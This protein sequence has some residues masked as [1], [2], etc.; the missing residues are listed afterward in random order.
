MIKEIQSSLESIF[1][2]PFRVAK[3]SLHGYPS[4]TIYPD[5]DGE[6]LFEVSIFFKDNIRIV[7]E[8]VP[9]RFAARS[10]QD[11]SK[12]D[13]EKRTAA[14]LYAKAIIK[15]SAKIDFSVNASSVDPLDFKT[16]PVEW[17]NFSCRITKI[18]VDV[19]GQV[20]D[21]PSIVVEWATKAIGMFLSLLNVEQISLENQEEGAKHISV[22]NRYERSSINR[23]LCLLKHGYVCKICGMSFERKYGELGKNYIHVHHIV[24]VS[25]MGGSYIINP[26]TDLI[27][28]CPNC[29]AMLHRQ[30]PPLTPEQLIEI[31]QNNAK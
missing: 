15:Q 7:L 28:V 27:P 24:P 6:E 25:R 5:N 21:N 17:H 26:E 2:I 11:I 4:L 16:W 30:D 19:H 9:Q 14:S 29:H 20:E 23:E 10:M 8:V 18:P 31:L 12:S 13:D 3:K 22:S 1:D